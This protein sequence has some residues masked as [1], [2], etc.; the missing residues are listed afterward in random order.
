MTL[1]TTPECNRTTNNEH[2]Y[3]EYIYIH[4]CRWRHTIVTDVHFSLLP[5]SFLRRY[6]LASYNSGSIPPI[7]RPKH[8]T[9]YTPPSTPTNTPV[10]NIWTHAGPMDT[11]NPPVSAETAETTSAGVP[12]GCKIYSA[13]SASLGWQAPHR[14]LRPL[15]IISGKLLVWGVKLS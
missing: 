11:T 5:G 8:S 7:P 1:T 6:P 9:R 15:L 14:N 4:K 3:E 12:F 10:Y 13:A 2:V